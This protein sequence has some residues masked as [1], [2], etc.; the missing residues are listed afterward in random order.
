MRSHHRPQEIRRLNDMYRG[1]RVAPIRNDGIDNVNN[2]P[3]HNGAH[4]HNIPDDNRDNDNEA[5]IMIKNS[6]DHDDRSV[7][8]SAEAE[9]GEVA[10]E[11]LQLQ[12]YKQA[13]LITCQTGAVAVQHEASSLCRRLKDV[14]T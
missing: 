1:V 3:Q 9:K 6:G 11:V 2:R 12:A 14:G 8:S 13:A 5:M 10:P 7:A 4:V